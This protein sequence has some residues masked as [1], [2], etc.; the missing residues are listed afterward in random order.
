[1]AEQTACLNP[2]GCHLA[3]PITCAAFAL[4]LMVFAAV[5]FFLIWGNISTTIPVLGKILP[6]PHK[7]EKYAKQ[8]RVFFL[9][10][11]GA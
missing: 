2:L 1:M 7:G 8:G 6:K 4:A 10:I 9:R 11:I 3:N 5:A